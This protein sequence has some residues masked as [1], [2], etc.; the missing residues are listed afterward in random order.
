MRVHVRHVAFSGMGE[1]ALGKMDNVQ[2][3]VG[4]QERGRGKVGW[5]RCKR[6]H[7][8]SRT[9]SPSEDK[10]DASGKLDHG[11]TRTGPADA[12]RPMEVGAE[13][14][15]ATS[16]RHLGERFGRHPGVAGE[17]RR[18][19]PVPFRSGPRRG[20]DLLRYRYETKVES[21]EDGWGKKSVQKRI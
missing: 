8:G 13:E 15:R 6:N 12:T 14:G 16:L 17:A 21:H 3:V 4:P 7:G 1:N 11:E 9:G 18:A 20:K 19:R 10:V 2:T 5:S